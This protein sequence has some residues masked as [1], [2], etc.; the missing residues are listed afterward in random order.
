MDHKQKT[1]RAQWGSNIGFILAAAGSAVGLGNIWK[2][3]GKAYEGGGGAFI[4]IYVAIVLLIGLP[5]MLAELSL[6]RA[7][8]KNAAG[9]YEV[10]GGKKFKWMGYV[11]IIT[12]FII[13]SYY[14]HV[15][16]WVLRYIVSYAT[17]AKKVFAE[18]L[19][20]FYGLLGYDLA[21]GTTF[22]PWIALVF[23][24]LFLALTAVIVLK[25][26]SGGIEKFNKV[27]M[28]ALFGILII[29]LVRS[30]T[31]EGAAE[32]LKYMLSLDWSKVNSTTIMAALGQ[33]FFSLSLGMS[34]MI[35][36]GSYVGKQENLAKNTAL[37]CGM[38]TLVALIAGFIIVPA[39]FATLGAEG[40]GKGGGFAFA[41]LAGV[42]ENMTG[43]V[44]F[45]LLF[46][47]LL[48]FA[49]ITSC[50]SLVESLV[51]FV[52]EEWGWSRKKSVIALCVTMYLV[53][54]VY[55]LSQASFDIKGIWW[56]FA[57][58]VTHPIMGDFMEFLTDRLLI[59][60]VA[61]GSCILA[62]WVWGAKNSV[63]E[64]RS[65]EGAKF[66]MAPVYTVLVKYVA[67]IAIVAILVY[68]FATGSTVS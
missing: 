9:T 8:K 47:L 37:I 62:G 33:A 68:S 17:E 11:S 51:A 29:L 19:G 24:A 48:F 39:V 20:Y 43:G 21:G 46:Y 35:T 61:L 44:I 56:D 14:A 49:A 52:Q 63:A 64:V 41:G 3:P 6:G 16:G 59:P 27:G 60:V 65:T 34:I 13:T 45:G 58:G 55:T 25:G 32:G 50:I 15:G 42:F 66:P 10:L 7:S 40:V 22:T 30:V 1:A 54:S 57:N 28:P 18:P 53:G 5:V 23:G 2:F 4:L 38:D 67:P 26:V 12:T 31:M 36:Y